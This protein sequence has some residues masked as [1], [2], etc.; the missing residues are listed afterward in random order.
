MKKFCFCALSAYPLIAGN[1]IS[2]IGGAELQQ[3]FIAQELVKRQFSVSFIVFDY[4]QPIS[5]TINEL[6]IIKTVSP[7]YSFSNIITFFS[8]TRTIWNALKKVDADIYFQAGCG[9]LT[10]LVGLF[11]KLHHKKFVYKIA[12]D[13]DVDMDSLNKGSIFFKFVYLFG[14]HRAK[15]IFSQSIY[16]KELLFKN[17]KVDSTVV[18]NLFPIPNEDH[19]EKATPPVVLWVGSIKPEWKQPELFLKLATCL[20]DIQFQMIGGPAMSFDYY[21]KIEREAEKIKN[22]DFLGF[23]PYPQVN[24]YF[25]KASVF[26]NTSSAEGFPNTFLQAWAHLTPVVSLNVDPDEVICKYSLGYHSRTFEKLIENVKTLIYDKRT[27]DVM[28]RNGRTYLENEHEI[29]KVVNKYLAF[30]DEMR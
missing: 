23:I 4:D 12:S 20:P 9:Y 14:I 25:I 17:Y 26:V 11:C 30:F 2:T 13:M 21:K 28:G 1:N 16:Q 24:N 29:S 22:L 10:G 15:K 5:E 8:A 19:F 3:V 18:K 6:E 7:D 27:R